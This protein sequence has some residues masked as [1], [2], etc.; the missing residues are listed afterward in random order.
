MSSSAPGRLLKPHF[1]LFAMLATVWVGCDVQQPD[2]Y[3]FGATL[4]SQETAELEAKARERLAQRGEGLFKVG[5][6]TGVEGFE[7]SLIDGFLYKRKLVAL[8]MNVQL[9]FLR[10]YQVPTRA[11]LEAGI[12]K[13]GWNLERLNIE[14][15]QMVLLRQG[16][17]AGKMAFKMG[18]RWEGKVTA[19]FDR[20]GGERRLKHVGE[21]YRFT[22]HDGVHRTE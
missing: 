18:H 20:V 5:E 11:Q 15:N 2:D 12:G 21:Y 16:N 7:F 22:S 9:E 4:N 3:Y 19:L 17:I 14:L 6:I 10:A 8:H 1:V 13:P